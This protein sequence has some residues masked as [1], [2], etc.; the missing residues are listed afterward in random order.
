[1]AKSRWR[2]AAASIPTHPLLLS[3]IPFDGELGKE[4][5]SRRWFLPEA[6]FPG[7][8]KVTPSLPSEVPLAL[9][10]GGEGQPEKRERAEAGLF[11]PPTLMAK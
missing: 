1:M 2:T 8:V 6:R 10:L 11:C 3:E 4:R 7:V 5:G 9:C